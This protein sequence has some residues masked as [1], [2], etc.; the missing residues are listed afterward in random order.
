MV[1]MD[2]AICER[3]R[4]PVINTS[5]RIKMEIPFNVLDVT[6]FLQYRAA[7][8]TALIHQL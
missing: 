8:F 1:C 7:V 4:N 2:L 3:K 6:L 5:T